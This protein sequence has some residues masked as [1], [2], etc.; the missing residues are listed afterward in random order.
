M[1][2]MWFCIIVNYLYKLSLVLLSCC[3]RFRFSLLKEGDIWVLVEKVVEEERV[4]IG[5]E[6]VDVLVKL[7]K[8]DMRRVLNVL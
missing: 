4:K 3:I 8:G 2:N 1:V 5:V 7:S 6:V